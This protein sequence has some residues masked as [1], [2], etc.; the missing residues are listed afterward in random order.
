MT[1]RSNLHRMRIYG[2]LITVFLLIGSVFGTLSVYIGD[3]NAIKSL[4]EQSKAVSVAELLWVHFAVAFLGLAA[5]G[6]VVI[7]L[8]CFYRGF[9][10]GYVVAAH[11]HSR[12]EIGLVNVLMSNHL[13]LLFTVPFLLCLSS[14]A[15]AFS[16][17]LFDSIRWSE[18]RVRTSFRLSGYLIFSGTFLFASA[19][20]AAIAFSLQRIMN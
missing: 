12:G 17:D 3:Q 8:I 15:L 1:K 10:I 14:L 18:G 5:F 7:P 2:V 6:F 11:I 19:I 4:V 20:F 13:V 9:S 16:R